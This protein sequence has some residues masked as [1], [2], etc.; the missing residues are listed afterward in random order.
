MPTDTAGYVALAKILISEKDF[1]EAE[2]Q[3]NKARSI[4]LTDQ[5]IYKLQANIHGLKGEYTEVIGSLREGLA[6]VAKKAEELAVTT[7]DKN[8][9]EIQRVRNARFELNYLLAEALIDIASDEDELKA[10]FVAEA[11]QCLE[12]IEKIQAETPAG[13]KILGRLAMLEG[14]DAKADGKEEKKKDE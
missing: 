13:T 3:L 9:P 4:D 8:D 7:E 12:Q 5:E 10:E 11:R 1:D 6:V 14:D 2:A